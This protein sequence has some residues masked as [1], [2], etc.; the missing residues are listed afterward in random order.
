MAGRELKQ[1]RDEGG[2]DEWRLDYNVLVRVHNRFRKQLYNPAKTQLLPEGVHL[3]IIRP[4]RVTYIT[5]E[6][7]TSQTIRD[8]WSAD[9]RATELA[10]YWKGETHFEL[11]VSPDRPL[12]VGTPPPGLRTMDQSGSSSGLSHDEAS[13]GLQNARREQQGQAFWRLRGSMLERVHQ[14]P[15]RELYE[16]ENL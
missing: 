5:Y 10:N 3:G 15:R 1:L 13:V 2:H 14:V 16:P 7:G 9:A 8:T 12:S 11:S 6:D 4:T